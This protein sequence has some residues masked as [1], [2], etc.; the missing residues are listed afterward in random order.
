MAPP[1]KLAAWNVSQVTSYAVRDLSL[2]RVGCSF[3][4]EGDASWYLVAADPRRYNVVLCEIVHGLERDRADYN[5]RCLTEVRRTARTVL[6]EHRGHHEL[7]VPVTRGRSLVGTLVCG[8]LLT[9]RPTASELSERWPGAAATGSDATDEELRRYVRGVLD[10]HIFAGGSI[11]AL[12]RY[13]EDLATV[14]AGGNPWSKPG[15]ASPWKLLLCAHPEITMWPAAA[16]LV[17]RDTNAAWTAAQR[18]YER[19]ALGLCRMPTHVLAFSPRHRAGTGP[20]AIQRMLQSDELQRACASIAAEMPGTICGRLG[21]DAAFVLTAMPES[22]PS[23]TRARLDGFAERWATRVRQRTSMDI[24]CGV[25]RRALHGGELPDR[26]D[27]ALVA[28]LWALH[29]NRQVVHY[30]SMAGANESATP[31]G[32]YRSSRALLQQF[33]ALE[34]QRTTISVEQ[35][36]K[37]VLWV[38]AGSFDAARSHFVELIWELMGVVERTGALSPRTAADLLERCSR[39]LHTAGSS[40]EAATHFGLIVAELENA[41]DGGRSFETRA[42]LDR[43]RRLVEQAVPTERI[44]LG[45]VARAVG[46]SP[47]HLSHSFRGAHG[48]GFAEL[49]RRVRLGRAQALLRDTELSVAEV[50]RQSGFSSPSYLFQSFRRL[51]GQTPEQYRAAARRP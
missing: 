45:N 37:D 33:G 24:A 47:S 15:A 44:T 38:S 42:K 11:D 51:A 2:L 41:L 10:G 35:V 43:A 40:S 1:P 6:G 36:I 4:R 48:L 18:T 17:R 25:G 3:V 13:V 14:L 5:A 26:Y 39:T 16:D 12:R 28:V 49:V 30:E 20:R 22:T 50:S 9:R 31:S 7:F 27:E 29:R 21:D 34:R 19:E 8:P 23:R 32:P 46:L